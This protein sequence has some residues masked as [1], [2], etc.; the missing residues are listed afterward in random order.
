M[1]AKPTPGLFITG[2]DTEVG[3]TF[4]ASI[5]VEQL[6][7]AGKRVGVYK[8]VASGCRTEGDALVSDD[9]LRLWNAAGQPGRLEQVCPQRFAAPLAPH[10]AAQ[11][12]GKQVDTALL[13]GGLDFWLANSDVVIVEGAGGLLSPISEKQF[14][15]DLAFDFGFPLIVVTRN[16]L[17]TINRTLSALVVAVTYREGMDVAAVVLND[18]PPDATDS[19]TAT[20][21]AELKGRCM[22]PVLGPLAWNAESLPEP[23]DWFTLAGV[24]QKS[25]GRRR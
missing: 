6:V 10:Q 23:V 9:A 8:P 4:I 5:I 13:R 22:P 7:A 18:P 20:N 25:P 3:K 12:E 19:S 1:K 21:L 24:E 14:V 16:T 15:A 11:A 2:T 17:G